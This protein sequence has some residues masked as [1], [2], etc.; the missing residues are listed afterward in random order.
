[1]TMCTMCQ[2]RAELRPYGKNGAMV[3][4]KCAMKDEPEARRRF[5]ALLASA[6]PVA[7]LDANGIRPATQDD[8]DIIQRAI[9]GNKPN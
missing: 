3:C 7:V 1:M 2:K 9:D 5:A 6:G 4:F 8:A